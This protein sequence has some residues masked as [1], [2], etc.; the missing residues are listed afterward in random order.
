MIAPSST[1]RSG[2]RNMA[3][4]GLLFALAGCGEGARPSPARSQPQQTVTPARETTSAQPALASQCAGTEVHQRH[5]SMFNCDVCH[6]CGATFGF[7]K[8]YTF[9]RGTTT[10]GGTLT[11]HTTTSPTTCAVACHYPMGGAARSIAWTTPGPLA[12]TA[13]HDTATTLSPAHPP[14]SADAPR[15]EC[16]A[17]HDV[18]TH[19]VGSGAV[20]LVPHV[21]GWMDQTSADFH[22]VSANRGL[23]NCKQCHAADLTG[24]VTGFSCGQCHDQRDTSGNVVSWK[25]NCVMC[26]G[27]TDNRSGAP[28]RAI[29]GYAA[30]AV[31]VGAHGAHVTGSGQAPPFDCSVCHVKPADALATDHIDEATTG[32]AP[33]ATI[34]FGGMAVLG[35]AG[36]TP[37]WDRT[38][39][40]C[41]NTYCHGA[42]L[43]GGAL[44]SPKW[45]KLDGSQ[46]ACGT[47]HGIPPLTSPHSTVTGGTSACNGCHSATVDPHGDIIPVSAGGKHI[48]GAIEATGGHSASW[49]DQTSPSFHAFSANQGL[50]SCQGCHGTNLDGVGG[51]TTVSCAQCHDQD[52]PPGVTTWKTNCV[53]CHGGIDSSSGAPPRTTWGNATDAVRTGAHTAHVSSTTLA[54]PFDCVVCHVKPNDALSPGHIDGPMAAVTFAGTAVVGGVTPQ[55]NRGGATCASTY[56]HGA[57]LPGGSAKTPIWTRLDGSQ[58][59][60]A[61]CHGA[62]PA[63][64]RHSAHAVSWSI[65]CW[66]CHP[67]DWVVAVR[68]ESHVNGA[69]DLNPSGST[70]GTFSDW[71]AAKAGRGT[72]RGTATGCHR[73]TYYWTGASPTGSCQ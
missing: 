5:V 13:C 52:L 46:A 20:V 63:T 35:L 43:S 49:M 22:A 31:R 27:G 30:D 67:G 24:G 47:C 7:D 19:A 50:G 10:A 2:R 68:P 53:M 61:A 34:T 4:A 6:P 71:S 58:K 41:S 59:T 56:C 37:T 14:V 62:P 42:T 66:A 44:T 16:L 51:S 64:G 69:V 9:P 23:A 57:T 28:P 73:G 3:V 12:C 32:N 70:Y 39:A 1:R 48:D 26:H 18:S 65:P 38:S 45:T 21:S 11:L 55:W 36:I 54:T 40:T 15:S 60:C 8:P 33:L 25:T 72:L 17:C 29:W